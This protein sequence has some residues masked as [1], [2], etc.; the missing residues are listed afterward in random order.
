MYKCVKRQKNK[1]KEL[2]PKDKQFLELNQ[3][4]YVKTNIFSNSNLTI[5]ESIVKYLK[6][7]KSL[8][9]H[10]ISLLLNRNERN[11]WTIYRN[12][13]KKRIK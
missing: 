11:I 10:Q 5:F 13:L 8:N 3:F 7:E 1:P 12:S 4:L 6:E 2:N 9:F